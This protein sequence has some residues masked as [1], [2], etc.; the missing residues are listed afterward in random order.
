MAHN[1][2]PGAMR[3]LFRL[4]IEIW[5]GEITEFY[6]FRSNIFENRSHFW[7]A[8]PEMGSQMTLGAL[9]PPHGM[10]STR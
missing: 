8:C 10:I 5:L 3:F 4:N 7:A 1:V 2:F 6:I 9:E